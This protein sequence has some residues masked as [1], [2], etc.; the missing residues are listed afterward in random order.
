M[1]K[2]KVI[3][4]EGE[5]MFVAPKNYVVNKK[6][7]MA[8]KVSDEMNVVAPID[9][10]GL[11]KPIEP[12]KQPDE[13]TG[14]QAQQYPTTQV[15]APSGGGSIGTLPSIQLGEPI[16]TAPTPEVVPPAPTKANIPLLPISF[17]A[18]PSMGG[19]GGG[20]SK[21]ATPKKKSLLA[22][23]WWVLLVIG[24]GGYIYYKKKK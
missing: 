23:Y 22:Q 12:P 11:D 3:I 8:H 17:G 2:E 18:A 21:E 24:V 1:T 6:T 5:H 9:E 20:G 4:F 15:T 14:Y 10:G 7:G 16:K 19:G 13:P